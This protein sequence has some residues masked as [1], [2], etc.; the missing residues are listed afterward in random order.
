M[1]HGGVLHYG[2][3]ALA[4]APWVC[5]IPAGR[6]NSDWS[7][8]LGLSIHLSLNAHA[9][10]VTLGGPLSAFARSGRAGEFSDGSHLQNASL[11]VF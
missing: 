10:E 5:V 6:A 1:Q 9:A 4:R 8:T 11:F 2:V 3:A 7:G